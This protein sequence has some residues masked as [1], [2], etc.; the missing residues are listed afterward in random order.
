MMI[1]SAALA[2]P[3]PESIGLL[4]LLPKFIAPGPPKLSPPVPRFCALKLWWL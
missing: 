2:K 4:V 1:P 3:K